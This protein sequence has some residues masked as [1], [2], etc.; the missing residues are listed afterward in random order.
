MD[1]GGLSFFLAVPAR[2][3]SS[4]SPRYG[5]G[6][7]GAGRQPGRFSEQHAVWMTPGQLL[8]TPWI[9]QLGAARARR[10]MSRHLR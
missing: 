2:M 6:E 8:A 5:G 1:F 4:L 10:L 3:S 9:P 7:G